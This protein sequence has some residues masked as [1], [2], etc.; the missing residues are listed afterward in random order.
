MTVARET[1]NGPEPDD[2]MPSD[3]VRLIGHRGA[4]LVESVDGDHATVCFIAG[5]REILPLK[6]LRRVKQRGSLY[7]TRRW[8][9]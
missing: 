8:S 7:D 9:E 3:W 1:L 2:I 5:R 4:G 6:S